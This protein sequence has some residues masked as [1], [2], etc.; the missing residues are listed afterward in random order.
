MLTA[1]NTTLGER[2]LINAKML[3]SHWGCWQDGWTFLTKCEIE[4]ACLKIVNSTLI[5]KIQLYAMVS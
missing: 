5:I 2:Q 1:N 3:L 4:E